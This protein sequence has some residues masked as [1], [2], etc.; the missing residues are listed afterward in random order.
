[1]FSYLDFSSLIGAALFVSLLTPFKRKLNNSNCCG[2]RRLRKQKCHREDINACD[3][4]AILYKA[5]GGICL[6]YE[7]FVYVFPKVYFYFSL[8]ACVVC[9]HACGAHRVHKRDSEAL[10]E[11][12]NKDAG[13]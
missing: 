7:G 2:G 12:P 1:M 8:C 4:R 6:Q 5:S 3:V 9:V 11:P 10:S 13:N